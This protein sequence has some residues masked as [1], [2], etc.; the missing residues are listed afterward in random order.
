MG[1]H[2]EAIRDLDK[3]ITLNRDSAYA[4]DNRGFAKMRL[5]DL[6]GAEQDINKSLELD[7]LNSYAYKNKGLLYIELGMF[8]QAIKQFYKARDLGYFEK[9]DNEVEELIA[10]YGLDG[11]NKR[12]VY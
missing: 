8:D 1:Q 12:G 7:A 5:G 10:E 9:Y 11:D 2:A 6:A 4:Y 3:A